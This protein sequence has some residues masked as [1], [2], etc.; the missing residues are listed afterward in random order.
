MNSRLTITIYVLIG[1]VLFIIAGSLPFGKSDIPSS[2]IFNSPV[3]I[4]LNTILFSLLVLCLFFSFKSSLH[5]ASFMLAHLGVAI[6]LAGAFISFLSEKNIT[7]LVPTDGVTSAQIE[8]QIQERDNAENKPLLDIT[9]FDLFCKNFN[10]EYFPVDTYQLYRKSDTSFPEFIM[11]AKIDENSLELGRHGKIGVSEL[12]TENG[13]NGWKLFYKLN[14]EFFLLIK[15]PADRSYQCNLEFIDGK[16]GE[17]TFIETTVNNPAVYKNW[18]IYLTD[19]DHNRYKYVI[20]T[21]RADPGRAL[22]IPGIW[23][24]MIGIAGLCYIIPGYRD[25]NISTLQEETF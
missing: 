12:K 11:D 15:K 13:F 4:F 23:M 19:Y 8:Q 9:G 3:F 17:K 5:Y 14:D 10:I 20:L 6:I 7:L 2:I 18:R 22:V 21:A 1:L 24:L 16:A 25:N